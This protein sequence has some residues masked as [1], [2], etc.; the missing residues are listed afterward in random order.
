MTACPKGQKPKR[1]RPKTRKDKKHLA[2]VAEQNCCV[3]GR[4]P[5]V[6]HHLMERFDDKIGRRDDK[7]TPPLH[8][9]YHNNA[10]GVHGPETE[11]GFLTRHRVNGKELALELWERS[12]G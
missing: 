2:Y 5:V 11:K 4:R 12:H 9:D 7:Y 1:M 8:P 10:R 3:S 6:V